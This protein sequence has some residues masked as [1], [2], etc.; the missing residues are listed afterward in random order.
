MKDHAEHAAVFI[1]NV[2]HS[3]EV[4]GSEL[5]AI[6]QQFVVLVPGFTVNNAVL[7]LDSRGGG[8][9][10][11]GVGVQAPES[12]LESTPDTVAG[13]AF[14]KHSG[15]FQLFINDH[16]AHV[17][18]LM[19]NMPHCSGDFGTREEAIKQQFVVGVPLCT[20]PHLSPT[21]GAGGGK[22]VYGVVVVFVV[23]RVVLVLVTCDVVFVENDAVTNLALALLLFTI[24][25]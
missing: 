16:A 23:V 24:V 7:Q 4:F 9:D 12:R 20:G 5:L 3:S 21:G 2:P 17:P 19:H 10:G 25:P 14:K 22:G 6:G 15:T 18:V 11:S 13:A 8:G 1:H